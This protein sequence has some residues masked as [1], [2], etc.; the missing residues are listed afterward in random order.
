VPKNILKIISNHKLLSTN[1]L[2]RRKNLFATKY[3]SDLL[4]L[5][6]F[7]G[8]SGRREQKFKIRKKEMKIEVGQAVLM[9]TE[10]N[11]MVWY[12]AETNSDEYGDFMGCNDDGESELLNVENVDQVR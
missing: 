5:F 9:S 10:Y 4:I 12:I 7:C 8:Y 1:D 6:V 2:R 11:G 3:K